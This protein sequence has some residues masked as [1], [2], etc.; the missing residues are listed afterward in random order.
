MCICDLELAFQ[1]TK[2]ISRIIWLNANGAIN[3]LNSRYKKLIRIC[4]SFKCIFFF[5]YTSIKNNNNKKKNLCTS[6]V[7]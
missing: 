4:Y 2:K 7:D 6:T 3:T 1:Y 5:Y